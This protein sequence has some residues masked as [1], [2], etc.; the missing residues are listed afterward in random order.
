MTITPGCVPDELEECF[1]VLG[2]TKGK[3]QAGNHWCLRDKQVA[4]KE[5]GLKSGSRESGAGPT[6]DPLS[7]Q[8]GAFGDCQ[9]WLGLFQN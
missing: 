4:N 5:D 8:G 6:T 9:S 7:A 3:A 1:V 2:S